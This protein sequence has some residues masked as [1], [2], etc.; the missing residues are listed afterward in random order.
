MRRLL[1]YALHV[2]VLV[3]LCVAI[4][5]SFIGRYIMDIVAAPGKGWAGMG[6]LLYILA[7]AVLM[8]VVLEGLWLVGIWVG[9]RDHREQ[10]SQDH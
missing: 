7:V 2:A 3:G 4:Y 1:V 10:P 5:D 6:G 9:H 8:V